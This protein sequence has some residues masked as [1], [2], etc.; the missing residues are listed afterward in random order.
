MKLQLLGG[1]LIAILAFS[2]CDDT[3]NDIGSSLTNNIDKLEITTDT[4]TISTRSISADSV[5]ARNSTAYLGKIRDP[6]TGDYVTGDCMIQF[7]TLEDYTQNFPIRD[8]V[9]SKL[10]GEIIADSCDIRLFYKSFYGDSLAAM[11]LTAYEMGKPMEEGVK[12][13]SNFDPSKEGYLRTDGLQ[14][15]QTYTLTD[16]S[17]NPKERNSKNYSRNVRIRLDKEYTDK[18]GT[19]Y[20]NYGTYVMR[21]YYKNPANFRNSY[22][23]IHNVVPGFF[24]KSQSGLGSMAYIANSQLNI[25]IRYKTT[26]KSKDRKRDSLVIASGIASFAGTEEVLQKTT[27]TNDHNILPKLVA[28]NTCTY[29][30]TPAGIFTEIT[31]PVEQI[32]SKHKNDTINSAKVVLTRINNSVQSDYALKAPTT[33][34]IIPKDSLYSFFENDRI[35]NNKN[36]FLATYDKGT[37]Y[38][39][40]TYTFNNISGLISAMNRS[41]KKSANWNKAVIIPVTTT[42]VTSKNAMG[43]DVNILTRIVHDMSMTSTRLVGGSHNTNAPVT[44]QVIYSK[45][46]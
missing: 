9:A 4:F 26:V 1:L 32:L 46:K 35:T 20:N 30:K 38:N 21:S 41:D 18:D 2:S 7:H 14:V 42:Y 6:E 17:V 24:L 10:N 34:L 22:R 16:L 5:L 19:V 8:S 40:N 27:V 45:F 25:Y 28:D 31:I 43:N 12:Y 33:L 11:K 39:Y 37:S 13:Y 44:I 29:L 3:T 23:F 15:D 36:S